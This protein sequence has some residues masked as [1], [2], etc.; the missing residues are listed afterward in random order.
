MIL[1]NREEKM[2]RSLLIVSG[3]VL[4]ASC[5]LFHRGSDS[6]KNPEAVTT[7][8]YSF[9]EN[10]C[11]TGQQTF[12]S[13]EDMCRGLLDDERNQNCARG[14]R[15]ERYKS[16]CGP[17]ESDTVPEPT[18]T[19]DPGETN[20]PTTTTVPFKRVIK[21]LT[22]EAKAKS[23]FTVVKSTDPTFGKLFT[24]SVDISEWKPKGE[25]FAEDV[26]C[27]NAR[28]YL[29]IFDFCSQSQ[30]KCALHKDGTGSI[31][32]QFYATNDQL[33]GIKAEEFS[34]ELGTILNFGTFVTPDQAQV[35]G[36]SIWINK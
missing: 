7:F 29:P 20:A 35:Q 32:M 14:L 17:L 9:D 28:L 34:S 36:G 23:T 11:K 3:S 22:I 2:I 12:T 8:S 33:C 30:T 4:L 19:P 24:V 5:Q 31:V 13:R 26:D 18:S 1:P 15:E 25:T 21:S 27:A 10:G 16:A 6:D